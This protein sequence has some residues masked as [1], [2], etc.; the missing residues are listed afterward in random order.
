MDNININAENINLWLL[1]HENK[2]QCVPWCA[3]QDVIS[4]GGEY[5]LC[6]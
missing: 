4:G 3:V 1:L 2:M 6:T 5:M